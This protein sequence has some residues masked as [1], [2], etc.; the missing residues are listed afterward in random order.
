MPDH[1][2]VFTLTFV[3]AWFLFRREPES[4]AILGGERTE[5]L[6]DETEAPSQSMSGDDSDAGGVP[7]GDPPPLNAD[8]KIVICRHCGAE[9]RPSFRYCR[10]CVRPGFA[11]GGTDATDGS[12]MTERSL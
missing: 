11:G 12:T 6:T 4:D 7:T 3:S 8:G 2:C 10:W 1:R 5:P 9:N